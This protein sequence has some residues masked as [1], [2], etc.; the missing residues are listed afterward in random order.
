M[1]FIDRRR[2]FGI[3]SQAILAGLCAG[4][5]MTAVSAEELRNFEIDASD[6]AASL[7]TFSRQAG[8]QMLFEHRAVQGYRTQAVQ[9]QF[10]P[11]KALE[12][13]LRESGLTYDFVNERTVVIRSAKQSDEVKPRKISATRFLQDGA[14]LRLAQ[15][16]DSVKSQGAGA[17]DRDKESRD[18]RGADQQSVEE[19]IVTAQKRSERLRDVPISIAVLSGIDLDAS[20]TQG[21]AEVLNRVPGVSTFVQSHGVRLSVRG[22][23]GT[24]D[25]FSGSSP[26]G[27]YL[28]S[29]PFGLISSAIVPDLNA[30]DL[31]RIEVLKGPQGTLYGASAQNGVVRVL[32][33][34]A[35]PNELE[36]KGRTWVS[37]T[38]YGGTNYRGDMAINAPI[39]DGKLAAR[40]VAGYAN[41]SGWI[42]RPPHQDA[43][44]AELRN[45]RL[46]LNMQATEQLS[47]G[48]SAWHTQDDFGS[49]STGDD[50]RFSSHLL[51]EPMYNDVDVYSLKVVY[52]VERFSLSS[53]TSYLDHARGSE[54]Y[55]ADLFFFTFPLLTQTFK[56]HMLSQEV[57]LSSTQ[58]GPWQWTVGSMYRDAEDRFAQ[59]QL[60][61]DYTLRSKSWAVFGELTRRLLGGRLE[62]TA[63]LR[64]FS[65]DVT[66]QENVQ[67]G[68]NP[69]LRSGGSFDQVSPRL[70]V[71]GHPSERT[72][73]YASYS[74]GF[75]SGMPQ[76]PFVLRTE[77]S[78]QPLEEDNLKNF[79]VGAKGTLLGGRVTYE[80]ALFYIDWQDVQQQ[81]L[82]LINGAPQ[83]ANVNGESASGW[84]ADLA[85]TTYPATG[86]ELGLALGWN[87][88]A[89]D[90]D[91]YP[92]NSTVPLARK[93][94]RLNMSPELT[95]G[96]RADY[97]FA[98][99]SR[100]YNGHLAVSGN[101]TSEQETRGMAGVPY[102]APGDEMLTSRMSFSIESP[103]GWEASLFVDNA[104]NEQGAALRWPP[105]VAT[106]DWDVRVRPRTIG[107][108]L[109]YAFRP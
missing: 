42:D 38:Q 9:G 93:G 35:N 105:A 6:A 95:V 47:V 26:I 104:N 109:D 99:G 15:A 10:E 77:P 52:D 92:P 7:S 72:M 67:V 29:A 49:F 60:F 79:E 32:T 70:V 12:R 73:V 80:A 4:A 103:S 23:T 101:Y 66:L 76:Q 51:D 83:T 106:P 1:T 53:A 40:V 94:D 78:Y 36:L 3:L 102:L 54:T 39:V 27:Y 2:R 33:K 68:G 14:T 58:E 44:D 82:V 97:V 96:A 108:Q 20:T 81:L 24:Q 71:T 64:R 85:L 8:L 65:D 48:L 22:V 19:I 46:K 59:P 90:D 16:D 18:I 31:D 43:N 37:S 89:L 63:G 34:D 57:T 74:E 56:A 28:D 61:N 21:V 13:L 69:L 62:L 11:A 30:Y 45:V 107:L 86:L 55:V 87:D 98:I 88:L 84:G 100:G 17:A 25:A 75:R 41:L 91:V 50:S 5:A